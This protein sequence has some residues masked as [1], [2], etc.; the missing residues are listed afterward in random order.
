MQVD[1]LPVADRSI[2]AIEGDEDGEAVEFVS[3]SLLHRAVDHG[4]CRVD[5]A[6]QSPPASGCAQPLDL[7]GAV[8]GA[9][10]V[11]CAEHTALSFCGGAEERMHRWSLR[12]A[13]RSRIRAC[14]WPG[15]YRSVAPVTAM[16]GGT[17]AFAAVVGSAR[18]LGP[19]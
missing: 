18:G 13:A 7:G 9:G 3:A 5:A 17:G 1:G 15:R 10:G 2:R 6:A 14:G 11:R 8:T 16:C 4:R 12:C 19:G